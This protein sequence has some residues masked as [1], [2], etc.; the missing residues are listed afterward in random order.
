MKEFHQIFKA[1]VHEAKMLFLI[2][3]AWVGDSDCTIIVPVR[4]GFYS[5]YPST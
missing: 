1:V 4:L 3:L 5:S 2:H